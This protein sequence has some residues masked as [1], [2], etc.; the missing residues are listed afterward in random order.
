MNEG[1]DMGGV[2]VVV[3][4]GWG[5][6]GDRVGVGWAEYVVGVGMGVLCGGNEG[7]W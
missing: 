7:W 5:C 3:R 6:D 2:V 4:Y 1:G